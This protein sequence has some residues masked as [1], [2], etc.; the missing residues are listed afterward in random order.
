ME[1]TGKIVLVLDVTEEIDYLNT[2]MMFTF[3]DEPFTFRDVI[4]A[5]VSALGCRSPA[6]TLKLND[7]AQLNAA[8]HDDYLYRHRLMTRLLKDVHHAIRLRVMAHLSPSFLN[9]N[10]NKT[11]TVCWTGPTVLAICFKPRILDYADQYSLGSDYVYPD[12]REPEGFL[13]AQQADVIIQP[14]RN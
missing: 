3:R 5:A 12:F 10:A 13:P 7:C 11:F 4:N 6:V 2:E 8:D 14:K 1:T 9:F